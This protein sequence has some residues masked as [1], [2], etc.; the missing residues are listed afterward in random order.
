MAITKHGYKP[1]PPDKLS[2][3]SDLD[4]SCRRDFCVGIT[5]SALASL[6]AMTQGDHTSLH[7]LRMGILPNIKPRPSDS[8]RVSCSCAVRCYTGVSRATL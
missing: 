8:L 3:I 5:N 2:W 6:Q 7:A 4:T 1:I